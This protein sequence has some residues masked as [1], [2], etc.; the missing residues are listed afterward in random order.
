MNVI[1]KIVSILALLGAVALMTGCASTKPVVKI[2]ERHTTDTVTTYAYVHDSIYE[3]RDRWR[4]GDT[5][6]VDRYKYVYKVIHDS[7]Y[8]CHVDSIPVIREVEVPI[9]S[10]G[11][12]YKSGV[13]LWIILAILALA[14]ALKIYLKFQSGGLL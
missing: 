14:A 1:Q 4:T 9:E 7:I 2:V 3:Y 13:A 11:F 5:V 8:E 10:H 12:L 6:Y